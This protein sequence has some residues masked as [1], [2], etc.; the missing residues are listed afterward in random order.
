MGLKH[1]YVVCSRKLPSWMYDV[2]SACVLSHRALCF[3][4]RSSG[5]SSSS[6]HSDAWTDSHSQGCGSRRGLARRQSIMRSVV[7]RFRGG[8]SISAAVF[9]KRFSRQP[10]LYSTEA[11]SS[12]QAILLPLRAP[13]RPG[14]PGPPR[15]LTPRL[16]ILSSLVSAARAKAPCRFHV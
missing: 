5:P 1:C 7:V 11:R 4:D 2:V 16:F 6:S 9:L 13:P 3:V 15:L 10:P 14:P 12:R 8:C